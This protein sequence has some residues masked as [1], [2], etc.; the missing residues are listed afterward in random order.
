M[1]DGAD[2]NAAQGSVLDGRVWSEWCRA[3]EEA[4]AVVLADSVPMDVLDRAEG[5]RYLSRLVRAS[6]NF[7]LEQ[8]NPK[9]PA[10][11]RAVDETL[12]LG[13]DN[14]DNVYLATPASGACTYRISGNRGTVHYLGFGAQAGGYGRTASLDTTGYLEAGDLEMDADG[15]FEIIASVQRPPATANW[16]RMTDAT[17]LI[18][19]RQTRVDH[20]AEI[21]AQVRIERIDGPAE[22]RPL[23]AERLVKSLTEGALFLKG[24]SAMFAQWT[25]SFRAEPNTLP[26]FPPEK[27]LA[28]GGDP[29]IAYHHGW[30]EL[31]DGEA[32]VI[33]LEPPAC[34]FWNFQLANY[35]M[36]SL[37][38]RYFPV[39]LNQ[40][41]THYEADG[42]VRIVV[43]ATDPGVANWMDTCG[44][45]HGTMCVRWVG[46]SEDPLPRTAV[47]KI[48]E[49]RG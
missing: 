48:A 25:E 34:D 44:H 45:A 13:M 11:T 7:F 36:E 32:L 43:A 1:A 31:A 40:G 35:W 39:H 38:Y 9:A 8:P 16:L 26:R 3:L 42:S 12:K 22:Q 19:V 17:S 49:L 15:N 14:P 28:A 33:D 23:T 24:S 27:A 2:V 20:D 5:W 41:S 37:D 47:V 30:F 6:L 18:Q 46:A 21:L 10:F 4:G 29:N